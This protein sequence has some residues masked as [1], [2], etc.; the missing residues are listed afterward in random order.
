MENQGLQKI[1]FEHEPF[2][3]VSKILS[4]VNSY[5]QKAEKKDI[6]LIFNN[7]LPVNLVVI[8]DQHRLAQ[9]LS[10]ALSNTIRFTQFN[11]VKF[12][13]SFIYYSDTNVL[14][15]FSIHDAGIGMNESKLNTVFTTDTT[16]SFD[17][18]ARFDDMEP[19]LNVCRKLIE[20]QG[21]KI[22]L[23]NKINEGT[24]LNFNLPYKRENAATTQNKTREYIKMTRIGKK[25]LVA[26]DIEF[27]Q[28]LVKNTLESWGCQVDIAVNGLEAINMVKKNE[29]D[30][31]L[32]DIQMPEMDGITATGLIRKLEQPEK[33]NL[34]I[35]AFTSVD[36]K[37]ES[38][39]VEAGMNS[40]ILKP[41]TEEKLYEKII[42]VLKNH[43]E[44]PV[45]NGQNDTSAF[46]ASPESR[47]PEEKL[48]SI[49]MIEM[50]SKNKPSFLE[51]M[52]VMFVDVINEDL[53]KLKIAADNNSWT[54][55]AQIAHKMKSTLGNMA[56]SSLLPYIKALEAGTGDREE[57]IKKLEEGVAKVL[58]QIRQDYST[59]FN[60]AT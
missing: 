43:S 20:M 27:N 34:P 26:E 13:L 52:L 59:L 51:K 7:T 32:M 1:E 44:T 45:N 49:A 58:L 10:G 57:M 33:A 15:D 6:R 42:S 37:E 35:I 18:A 23:T 22:Y 39:Y 4:V 17:S 5:Q 24:I 50:I 3:V 56:V 48:Y 55:V 54:E 47:Q 60:P 38:K 9:I 41:Y 8:G 11:K 14:I 19:G 36:F 21:G 28:L 40:Y 12:E 31:V 2:K 46:K 53:G 29:Y 30:L 25:V 16:E